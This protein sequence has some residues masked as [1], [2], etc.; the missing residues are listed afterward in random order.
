[1]VP[2]QGCHR[3]MHNLAKVAIKPPGNR[4]DATPMRHAPR[5]EG[6][7]AR[8]MLAETWLETGPPLRPALCD[9]CICAE[10]HSRPT[11]RACFYSESVRLQVTSPSFRPSWCDVILHGDGPLTRPVI[12]RHSWFTRAHFHDD[13]PPGAFGSGMLGRVQQRRSTWAV[14]GRG[15]TKRQSSTSG[16]TFVQP[17]ITSPN[18]SPG[19][20][21]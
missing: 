1:M 4:D 20:P 13:L 11:C 21:L 16:L 12:D 9:H 14:I 3:E 6:G 17:S 5:R 8:T 10:I 18:P 19:P 2:C 15:G 7:T